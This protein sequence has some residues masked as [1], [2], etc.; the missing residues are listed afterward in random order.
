MIYGVYKEPTKEKLK[1]GFFF[2]SLDHNIVV[3]FEPLSQGEESYQQNTNR[4]TKRG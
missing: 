4:I 2:L 3:W 1:R